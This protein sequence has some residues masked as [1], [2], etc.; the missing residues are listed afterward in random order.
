LS[1]CGSGC[2]LAWWRLETPAPRARDTR[3]ARLVAL[4]ALPAWLR[5]RGLTRSSPPVRWRRWPR[6]RIDGHACAEKNLT[7]Q[8]FGPARSRCFEKYRI[9]IRGSDPGAPQN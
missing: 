9:Q 2:H 7:G 4:V 3:R 5:Q 6:R 1:I 8:V